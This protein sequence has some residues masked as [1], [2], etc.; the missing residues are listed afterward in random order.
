MIHDG[1]LAELPLD[2][3]GIRRVWADAGGDQWV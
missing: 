3:D 1:D 2:E